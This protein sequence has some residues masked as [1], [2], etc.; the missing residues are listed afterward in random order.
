MVARAT[1]I[2]PTLNEWLQ[3]FNFKI[4]S[5]VRYSETDMSGHVNNTS[6]FVYF[7]QA[8]VEYLDSLRFFNS[9]VNAVTADLSCHYHN[10]AF[11]PDT[12]QIGVRVAKIGNKSF[13][14]EYYI[15]SS[16]DEKL[17]ATGQGTLVVIDLETKQSTT[18]P[19]DIRDAIIAK[20]G[21]ELIN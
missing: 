1:Y 3:K 6:Y 17:I 4:E 7:E 13:D 9:T 21:L 12:L 11:F 10:E 2:A 18:I 20:E 5:K 19:K 16:H 15:L 14:L 8:R